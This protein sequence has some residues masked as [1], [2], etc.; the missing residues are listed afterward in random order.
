MCRL[1]FAKDLILLFSCFFLHLTL[2]AQN[3]ITQET[4]SRYTADNTWR[5]VSTVD[6]D[7]EG[8]HLIKEREST[9]NEFTGDWYFS[10][11]KWFDI[12]NNT[13]REINRSFI[14]Q[15]EGFFVRDVQYTYAESGQLLLTLFFFKESNN[16]PSKLVLQIENEYLEGCSYLERYYQANFDTEELIFARTQIVLYDEECQFARFINSFD[17]NDSIDQL[18]STVRV[19]YEPLNEGRQRIV[20][21]TICPPNIVNCQEW[22]IKERQIF[23]A[24]GRMTLRENGARDDFFRTLTT[25][26]YEPNQTVY[27]SRN[28]I[29]LNGVNQVLTSIESETFNLEEKLLYRKRVESFN[30][31]EWTNVYNENGFIEQEIRSRKIKEDNTTQVFLDTTSYSYQYYC[32]GLVSEIIQHRGGRKNRT[33]YSYR[34]PTNCGTTSPIVSPFVLFPNPAT[35]F[36]TVASE[37]FVDTRLT[38][39]VFDVHGRIIQIQQND[40]NVNQVIDLSQLSNGVYY[41]QINNVE[42]NLTQPFIVNK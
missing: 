3:P 29:K 18:L 17:P 36:I 16:Q 26:E 33:T 31:E 41:L 9:Y 5:K 34:Y 2:L 12:N 10:T 40:R 4:T 13:V 39:S 1:L 30:L 27:V 38:I 37:Q 6:Y 42:E 11:E 8:E 24:T 32:D 19:T 21:E 14:S 25:I 23:D 22:A 35:S 28:F 20:E 15:D 7:Y